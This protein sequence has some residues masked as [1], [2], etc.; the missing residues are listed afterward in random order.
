MAKVSIQT[1]EKLV[2]DFDQA[3]AATMK[4]AVS[5]ANSVP[6]LREQVADLVEL[7]AALRNEVERLRR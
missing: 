3:A 5:A 6:A 7:V 4:N 1:G 2:K